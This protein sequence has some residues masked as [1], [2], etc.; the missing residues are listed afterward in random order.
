M[1]LIVKGAP[2]ELASVTTCAVL[3]WPTTVLENDK[4]VGVSTAVGGVATTWIKTA[5]TLEATYVDPPNLAVIEW[6]PRV[7]EDVEKLAYSPLVWRGTVPNAVVPSRNVTEPERQF[8]DEPDGVTVA[9]KLAGW[10]SADGLGDE[11]SE[12]VEGRGWMFTDEELLLPWVRLSP[13]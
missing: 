11:V 1:L 12:I 8:V 5:E 10:P 3:V 13:E 2:P 9:V 6:F 7:N 4:E